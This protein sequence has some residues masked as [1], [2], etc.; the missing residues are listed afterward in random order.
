MKKAMLVIALTLVSMT[1]FAQTYD[2]QGKVVKHVSIGGNNFNAEAH[3]TTHN[4]TSDAY[5]NIDSKSVDCSNIGTSW[6]ASYLMVETKEGQ[7][8]V[9][10][11]PR[12][13]SVEEKVCRIPFSRD[14]DKQ[15]QTLTTWVDPCN[16]LLVSEGFQYRIVEGL[17][18]VPFTVAKKHGKTE[19][20]EACYSVGKP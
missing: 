6:D 13:V 7:V 12:T 9:Q 20:G 15:L 18:C 14:P 2:Q 5:C 16:P 3:V 8:A 1:A 4:R 11:K 10:M 17:M 19:T